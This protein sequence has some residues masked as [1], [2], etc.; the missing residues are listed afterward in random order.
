[1]TAMNTIINF[2]DP[3]NFD[4]FLGFCASRGFSRRTQL[5]EQMQENNLKLLHII[6]FRIFQFQH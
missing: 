6:Y 5:H 2:L 3:Y 4:T 1:M